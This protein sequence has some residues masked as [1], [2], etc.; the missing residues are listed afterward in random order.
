MDRN[1]CSDCQ[2][3]EITRRGTILCD[4]CTE[5]RK[6]S[7]KLRKDINLDSILNK[8]TGLEKEVE[9]NRKIAENYLA[10]IHT[11]EKELERKI[12]KPI[13]N[14]ELERE[15]QRLNDT[16]IKLRE[17]NRKLI[18]SREAYEMTHE[19]LKIDNQKLLVEN[20]RL[21]YLC[22]NEKNV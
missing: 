15:N 8:N 16:I 1:L 10:R 22:E 2:K 11:L 18:E 21:K 19:Q 12:D 20:A 3:K 6:N 9:E 5:L 4:D 17:E 14:S 7:I 13:Y